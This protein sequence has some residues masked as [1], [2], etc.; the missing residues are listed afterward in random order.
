[1][2]SFLRQR[3]LLHQ[4]AGPCQSK[5]AY[6]GVD[7][8]GPDLHIGHLLPLLTLKRLGTLGVEPIVLIG[9]ATAQIGDPSGKKSERELLSPEAVQSNTESLHGQILK[10]VP[11]A[12]ILNNLDWVSGISAL[13]L[14]RDLGKHFAVNNMLAKENVASRL[15]SGISFTEFSYQILQALDFLHLFREH[16]CSLQIGGSDQWGNITAGLE[17]IRKTTHQQ[18]S[19]ITIPLLLNPDGTK[20]GKSEGQ[21]VWLNKGKTHP[22]NFFQFWRN[23]PDSA[24]EILLLQLTNVSEDIKE[25]CAGKPGKAQELLG[26]ELVKEVHGEDEMRKVQ[27]CAECLFK[28]SAPSHSNLIELQK[29]LPNHETSHSG[30]VEALVTANLCPSKSQARRDIQAKGVKANGNTGTEGTQLVKGPNLIQKAKRISLS[31]PLIKQK[32]MKSFHPNQTVNCKN[33]D[34]AFPNLQAKPYVI[35]RISYAGYIWL[36]DQ[37]HPAGAIGPY[38]PERFEATS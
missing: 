25:I 34:L 14:L 8:T 17:L 26:L 15:D 2:L 23:T 33:P 24:V 20:M 11:T 29:A 32:T 12:K 22:F 21:A 9:G 16:N 5:A 3:Q 38:I 10:L 36:K 7:P 4:S 1:M 31:S 37:E 35:S 18:A 28:G 6:V 30:L 27:E 13:T 19:G